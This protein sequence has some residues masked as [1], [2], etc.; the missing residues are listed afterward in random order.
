MSA[1]GVCIVR[2][3]SA[4]VFAGQ[5]TKKNLA[6]GTVEMKDA[7][8]LWM[9]VGAAS[10]SQLAVDGVAKPAECRFPCAVPKI[11]LAEVIEI[12]PASEQ[13]VKTINKVKPWQV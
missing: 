6:D 5:I 7:R 9:W 8:R 13:A 10:L 1:S 4:G 3:R 11:E 2:T 12:I